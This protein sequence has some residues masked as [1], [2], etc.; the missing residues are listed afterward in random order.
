MQCARHNVPVRVH[1]DAI[2]VFYATCDL[3]E[4]EGVKLQLT[5]DSYIVPINQA[6]PMV[7]F[8]NNPTK[9]DTGKISD[10]FHNFDEL[11]EHR[12]LLFLNLCKYQYSWCSK[13]HADGT[14]FEQY[15]IAGISPGRDLKDD[16]ITYHLPIRLWDEAVRICDRVL[17][18]APE[19]DGHTSNDVLI[20]LKEML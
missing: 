9:V 19:W 14:M 16:Q 2:D 12:H 8:V 3:C 20:R 15:F 11:Y 13:L 7:G 1:G 17:D 5:F 6:N 10:G 18:N 4:A